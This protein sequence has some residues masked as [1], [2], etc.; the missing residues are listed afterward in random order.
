[1]Q[2]IYKAV[3]LVAAYNAKNILESQGIECVVGREGFTAGY[4]FAG[5]DAS[6]EVWIL[7][8]DRLDEAGRILDATLHAQEVAGADKPWTCPNCRERIEGQFGQC[9][10]CQTA[11]PERSR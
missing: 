9:W 1:M 11:R 4:G 10:R 5:I 6:P 3:D 8:D 7:D 2:L